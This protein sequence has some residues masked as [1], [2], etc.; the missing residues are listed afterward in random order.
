MPNIDVPLS[1]DNVSKSMYALGN[2]QHDALLED[3]PA[4]E[5]A[6]SSLFIVIHDKIACR[7]REVFA[8]IQ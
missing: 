7:I 1:S 8:A 4:A 2:I 3:N 5:C 6:L